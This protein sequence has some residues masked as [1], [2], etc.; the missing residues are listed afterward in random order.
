M[1][2][3]YINFE[4]FYRESDSDLSYKLG[5]GSD[6]TSISNGTAESSLEQW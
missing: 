1:S 2:K 5:D 6:D 4:C 3:T